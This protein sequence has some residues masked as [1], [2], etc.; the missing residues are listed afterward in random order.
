MP[1]E[2]AFLSHVGCWRNENQDS[3]LQ[4]PEQNVF[5]VA[6]GMG[7]LAE[8]SAASRLACKAF[9]YQVDHNPHNLMMY[10]QYAHE[11]V[12]KM[13]KQRGFRPNEVGT[14]GVVLQLDPL[15]RAASVCWCGD[16][17]LY[18]FKATAGRLEQVT[19][20]HSYVQ[21]LVDLGQITPEQALHHS[22][23]NII[24]HAIGI[25]SA[26]GLKVGTRRRAVEE[27]DVLILC[28]DGLNNEVSFEQ[29]EYLCQQ[30]CS[31]PQEL[32]EQLVASALSGG[33]HD[34]VTVGVIKVGFEEN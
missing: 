5:A 13:A 28:T 31:A 6:D 12:L 20:D 1:F 3:F 19:I 2:H 23:R 26:E 8:G 14:T 30:F 24:T 27:G 25:G 9:G 10:F 16:S 7:G 18:H 4:A 21:R 33:G 32:V 34:N 15:R 29:M 11:L 22:D 17:R